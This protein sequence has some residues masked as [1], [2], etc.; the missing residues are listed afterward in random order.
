MP[1]PTSNVA[2][3]QAALNALGRN[4][5]QLRIALAVALA[6]VWYL[7]LYRP[8]VGRIDATQK[9][10]DTEHKRLAAADEIERLRTEVK[11]FHDR[12]PPRPDPNEAIEY[13]LDGVKARPVRLVS[14][15]PVPSKE[16]GPYRM[17]T[18]KLVAGGSYADLDDLLRWVE[19]NP[20]LFRVD[21]ITITPAEMKGQQRS[22]LDTAAEPQFDMQLVILGVL[23]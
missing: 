17:V 19:T 18:V 8:L 4:P 11:R 15:S 2:A 5:L 3:L 23:G 6:L 13:I 21:E 22:S 10:L 12:L 14:L 16:M 7:A 1:A 20:R 9:R